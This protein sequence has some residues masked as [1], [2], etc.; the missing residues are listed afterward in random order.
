[1]PGVTFI[2]TLKAEPIDFLLPD[3]FE[4]VMK[5]NLELAGFA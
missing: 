2:A 1:M 3:L 4:G 5:S